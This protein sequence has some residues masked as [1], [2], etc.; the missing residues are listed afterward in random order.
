MDLNYESLHSDILRKCN[1]FCIF[2]RKESAEDKLFLFSWLLNSGI[3]G[4]SGRRLTLPKVV[5]CEVEQVCPW[6]P[7]SWPQEADQRGQWGCVKLSQSNK[8]LEVAGPKTYS[9]RWDYLRE[10]FQEQKFPKLYQNISAFLTLVLCTI[11][12]FWICSNEGSSSFH[13]GHLFCLLSA[14]FGVFSI[15]KLICGCSTQTSTG[16]SATFFIQNRH[17]AS[18][19]PTTPITEHPP[20]ES[21]FSGRKK[22]TVNGVRD[23]LVP[24]NIWEEHS[25]QSDLLFIWSAPGGKRT[26]F[27]LCITHEI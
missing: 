20:Y 19:L 1:S 14:C 2:G 7:W 10:V 23:N 24:K 6:D 18:L 25:H 21:I 15:F 3:E 5:E 26:V 27:L 17:M 8:P 4:M 13:P 9:W 11:L 22:T 12:I 16:P